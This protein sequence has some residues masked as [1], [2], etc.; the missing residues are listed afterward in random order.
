MIALAVVKKM[1][2]QHNL[3]SGFLEGSLFIVDFWL[4]AGYLL[5]VC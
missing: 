4:T 3:I 2:V 1:N 5:V